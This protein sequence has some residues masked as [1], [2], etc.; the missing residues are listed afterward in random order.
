MTASNRNTLEEAEHH[1]GEI[2]RAVQRIPF[3]KVTTYGTVAQMIGKPRNARQVGTALKLLPRNPNDPRN[4]TSS[5]SLD[6]QFDP[7][8]GFLDERIF[9][10]YR[11]PLRPP[12]TE[13]RHEPLYHTENVPWWRVLGFGGIVSMR[14]DRYAR[15]FQV[16]KLREEGIECNNYRVNMKAVRWDAIIEQDTESE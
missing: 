16:E 4:P 5:Q 9:L 12:E 7:N 14:D 8:E 13:Q 2:Y 1:Y 11:E 15:D 3:G 6:Q 10:T